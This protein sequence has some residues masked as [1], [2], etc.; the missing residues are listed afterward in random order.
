MATDFWEVLKE[1]RDEETRLEAELKTI[2]ATIPGIELLAKRSQAPF[3]YLQPAPSY[4][5]VNHLAKPYTLMGTRQAITSYLESESVPRM[6]SDITKALIDGGI[7]SKSTDF[8]GMIGSTLTQMKG[9]GLV[10]RVE[11]G[12]R[13]TKPS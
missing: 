2:R 12:W 13:L 8:A 7:V 9:D 6:P 10:E 3:P 5:T 4:L 11:D 1:M